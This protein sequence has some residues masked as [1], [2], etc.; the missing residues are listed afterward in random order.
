MVLFCMYSWARG[1][2]VRNINFVF[3]FQNGKSSF[4]L[5]FSGMDSVAEKVAP[6]EVMS[7][8]MLCGGFIFCWNNVRLWLCRGMQELVPVEILCVKTRDYEL[9]F[10]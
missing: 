3:S 7:F 8:L 4:I 2:Q 6:L 9:S 1:K 10:V 5:R